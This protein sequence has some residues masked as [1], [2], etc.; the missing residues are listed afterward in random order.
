MISL[1]QHLAPIFVER[2][3][4]SAAEGIVLAVLVWALLRIFLRYSSGN[5]FAIWFC[6]LLAIAALPLFA[7]SGVASFHLGSFSLPSLAGQI[8]MPGSWA[9]WLFVGWAAGAG[10]LLLRLG[11]G[12]WRVRQFRSACSEL[13]PATL[14]PAIAGLLRDFA[15]FR[16][17]R[18]LV[19]ET[20]AVPAAVGFFQPAIV[21]PAWL[22]PKLSMD[23][24]K[25]VL[26]HELAHLRRW[27]DWTNLAQNIVR[28]LFFF[29]PAV[30]WIQRQLTLEREMACDDIVLAQNASPRAYA[31][32]LISFAEKLQSTRAMALAQTLVGRMQQMSPRLAR[33]LNAKRPLSTRLCRSGMALSF[34][35]VALIFGAVSYAPPIVAFRNQAESGRSLTPMAQP[36]LSLS[37]ARLE[38]AALAHSMEAHAIRASLKEG[39]FAAPAPKARKISAVAPQSHPAVVP[40]KFNTRLQRHVDAIH[41]VAIQQS[42]VV[43]ET[44]VIVRTQFDPSGAGT[45]TLCIWRVRGITHAEEKLD[46]TIFV[47]SI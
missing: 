14:D 9:S 23:E 25:L 43:Q 15:S 3:L 4:N 41:A 19:S 8:V 29:H 38:N 21:L 27:D 32:S 6:A 40:L 24:I 31:S 16:P 17:V 33:I 45:W 28:A 7:G 35:L 44:I 30:W 5:R 47:S 34:G 13:D 10:F 18:L 37:R 42:P 36:A 1:L 20:A 11:I 22:L 12:L 39:R 2:V 46:P 26:L